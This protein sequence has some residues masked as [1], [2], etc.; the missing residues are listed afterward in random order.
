MAQSIPGL[1]D[2]QKILPDIHRPEANSMIPDLIKNNQA[3][4]RKHAAGPLAA[5]GHGP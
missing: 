2:F 5:E 3:V 4:G 1:N